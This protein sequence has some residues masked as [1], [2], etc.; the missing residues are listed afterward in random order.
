[1]WAILESLTLWNGGSMTYTSWI[2]TLHF[3][4]RYM[5][6]WMLY[7]IEMIGVHVDIDVEIMIWHWLHI[8]F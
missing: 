1:M 3:A 8:D 7:I 2:D 6:E 4:V 5:D